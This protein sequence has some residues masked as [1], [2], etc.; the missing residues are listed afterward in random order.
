VRSAQESKLFK[1]GYVIPAKT[2][3]DITSCGYKVDYHEGYFKI[4]PFAQLVS[5]IKKKIRKN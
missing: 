5:I 1:S 4:D 3:L 2:Y